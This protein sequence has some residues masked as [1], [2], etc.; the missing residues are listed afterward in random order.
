MKIYKI[1]FNTSLFIS[2]IFAIVSWWFRSATSD[3]GKWIENISI[4]IFASALLL[5]GSSLIGYIVEDHKIRIEYYFKLHSLRSKVLILSTIPSENNIAEELCNIITEINEL[6]E[7]YFSMVEQDFIFYKHRKPIQKLLEIQSYLYEYSN[8][9]YI[10]EIKF[11]EYIACTKDK[12]G[13]RNYSK[14]E[15]RNDIK[16]F[17]KA[18]D[19]FNDSGDPFVIFLDN[20]IHE[21]HTLIIKKPHQK[22]IRKDKHKPAP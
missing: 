13:N 9:C 17:I 4:G 18:M 10:A 5:V 1:T 12:N 8:L 7:G 19:N 22:N 14:E 20:K 11:R 16:D 21:Y 3:C 6:F 2:I 15:L